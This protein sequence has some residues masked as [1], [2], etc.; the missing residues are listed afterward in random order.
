MSKRRENTCRES[1]G[2]LQTTGYRAAQPHI[3]GTALKR[4]AEKWASTRISRFGRVV[5]VPY[6]EQ[7]QFTRGPLEPA[8]EVLRGR[9]G[10]FTDMVGDL[11]PPEPVQPHLQHVDDMRDALGREVLL[12]RSN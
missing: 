2:W 5:S 10:L 11:V 8:P 12:E 3:T 1:I 4:D 7:I 9:L 6:S